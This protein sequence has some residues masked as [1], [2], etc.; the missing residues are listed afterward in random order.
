MKR[1]P[2]STPKIIFSINSAIMQ[3]THDSSPKTSILSKKLFNL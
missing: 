1:V 3:N 2:G